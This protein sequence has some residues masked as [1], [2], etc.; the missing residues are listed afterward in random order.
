MVAH[1]NHRQTRAQS[2][3]DAEPHPQRPSGPSGP[4]G[5]GSARTFSLWALAALAV[6]VAV[7]VV[8]WLTLRDA[9]F[10]GIPAFD[11][12]IHYQRAFSILHDG[13]PEQ[14]VPWGSP[15]YPYVAALVWA[16]LGEQTIVLFAAQ[17]VLGLLAV[18]L[19]AWSLAP[20]L[21]QRGAW[22]AALLYG[23]HP[24]AVFF[25]VRYQPVA[26]TVVL[27]LI[28]LRLLFYGRRR[29]GATLLGGLLSGLGFL[30][31]PLIF[32][33]LAVAAVWIRLRPP[34]ARG[35]DGDARGASASVT[36]AVVLAVAF[37]VPVGV[38]SAHHAGL[39]GGGPL[40]NWSSPVHFERTLE[41]TTCGTARSTHPPAWFSPASAQSQANEAAGRAV[42][43]WDRATHFLAEGMKN[44]VER[45]LTAIRSLLCR[46][47]YLING[48][49]LPDPV[50]PAFV[51]GRASPALAWGAYVF[52]AYLLLG[53]W[54]LLLARR[55]TGWERL[56]PPLL[57]LMIANL[58]GLQTAA[59][60][61]MALLTLLPAAALAVQRLPD[62]VAMARAADRSRWLVLGTLLLA[63]LSACDLPQVGARH[64]NPAE[65]LRVEAGLL[66][67]QQNRQAASQ[68]LQ[69]A[70]KRDPDNAMVHSDLGG[71]L[72]RE[73][74]PRAAVE[75]YRKAL[76]LD[77]TNEQA[78]YG[79]AEVL[80]S[81]GAYAEAESISLRLV[82]AHPVHPL[83]LNQLATIMMMAG[84][85]DV[86]RYALTRALEISPDY[87][88]AQINLMALEKAE[89]ES[90]AMA[91]PED[92]MPPEESPLW[93]IGVAV[94]NALRN[95]DLARADSLTAA[96]LEQHPDQLL[97][98]YLRG[99]Y[100]LQSNQPGQ[101]ADLLKE[102]V[103]RAPGRLL[104]T[105][106]AAQALAAAG[107]RQEA[108]ELVQRSLE[109]A[110]DGR[111]QAGLQRLVSAVC[112][113]TLPE[114]P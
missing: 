83:Y 81:Q 106:F 5:V 7:R 32:F 69:A 100:L 85:F 77:P 111:N 78:L 28:V 21:S 89:K 87:Q 47:V 94:R 93:D 29:L 71:V 70:L 73:D 79:L 110:A 34:S 8:G 76:R 41:P 31:Q 61:W 22:I 68:L 80:R 62:V 96:A 9:F 30:L 88:V 18:P 2:A 90:G 58:V 74:L 105:R 66:L 103:R 67:Q 113:P 98:Q 109:Q 35:T 38:M 53:L 57:A 15:L 52:P 17:L 27:A 16:I 19:V 44:L 104:T 51:L 63:A 3:A 97:V 10:T 82:G 40:W 84:K 39:R 56:A 48:R 4:T 46:A 65:D 101:A 1:G 91:L 37:I 12:A 99:M 72:V 25:E 112:D 75:E 102:V 13:F 20:V 45:P 50:S 43:E 23:V 107:R 114:A 92:Q 42:G 6:A 26:W 64:A 86:A 14:V 95:Q 49:E 54:G 36:A 60:R 108:C 11:D 59:T 24:L 55:T 33:A